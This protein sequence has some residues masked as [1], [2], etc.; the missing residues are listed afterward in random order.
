[1]YP[2]VGFLRVLHQKMRASGL[3]QGAL[4]VW[5]IPKVVHPR[6]RRRARYSKLSCD[7]T[8]SEPSGHVTPSLHPSAINEVIRPALA[9]SREG[10]GA[11]SASAAPPRSPR[12]SL[13]ARRRVEAP[14][15]SR[16]S[17]TQPVAESPKAG[18]ASRIGSYDASIRTRELHLI[19]TFSTSPAPLRRRRR[20]GRAIRRVLVRSEDARLE[21][22]CRPRKRR[23]QRR[24]H[25]SFDVDGSRR[26]D[27]PD[28]G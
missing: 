3:V 25:G 16:A 5:K 24:H 22:Q 14:G 11:Y 9:V 12:P 4:S 15:E 6:S 27:Q 23:R 8:G 18:R 26:N 19:R 17:Q 13:P 1:M 2:H 20:R 21:R 28:D 10:G 7:A